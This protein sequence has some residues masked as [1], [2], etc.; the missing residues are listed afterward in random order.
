[1]KPHYFLLALAVLSLTLSVSGCSRA[2]RDETVD[3]SLF[4]TMQSDGEWAVIS[5]PYVAFREAP[6]PSSNVMAHGR[7]GDIAHVEGKALVPVEKE[8]TSVIWYRF[9]IGYVAENSVV[10]YPNKLKAQ[11]AA[12]ELQA[13]NQ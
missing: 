11:S 3:L 7:L 1:M 5:E 8:N 4:E 13:D 12:T 6:D 2:D 10:I 9:E